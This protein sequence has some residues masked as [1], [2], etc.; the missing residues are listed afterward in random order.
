MTLTAATAMLV[1]LLCATPAAAQVRVGQG[2]GVPSPGT[3]PGSRILVLRAEPVDIAEAVSRHPFSADTVTTTTRVLADGNRLEERTEGS[4]MRD[5]QGNLRRVQTIGGLAGANAPV[6]IVTITLPQERVQLRLDETR[7]IA[8]RLQLP[9]SLPPPAESGR[10][11]ETRTEALPP[12]SVDGVRA[13]GSR[14]VTTL[15]AGSVGNEQPIEIVNERWYAPDLQVVVQ[16]RRVDPRFGEVMYRLTNIN[17]GD[18]PKHL[19]EVPP[20]FT[21]EEQRPTPTFQRRPDAGIE[22]PR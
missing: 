17:R 9:P 6:Q 7:K 2:R 5:A 8:F 3:D 14:T 20:D 11:G 19:F 1:A 4:L 16:T 13:E 18:P 21:I 22:H 15:P 12:I 10:R